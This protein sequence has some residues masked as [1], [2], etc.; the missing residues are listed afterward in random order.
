MALLLLLSQ[1]GL[2]RFLAQSCMSTDCLLCFD[3]IGWA[4]RRASDP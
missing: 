4:S 1:T 2:T 3:T